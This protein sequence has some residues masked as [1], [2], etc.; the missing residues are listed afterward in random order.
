MITLI[1]YCL[2]MF[3]LL[4]IGESIPKKIA[5][6]IFTFLE[7]GFFTLLI[8]QNLKSKRN[9]FVVI[10]FSVAFVVFQVLYLTLMKHRRQL[11]SIPIG[12]E[13]IFIFIFIFLFLSEQIKVDTEPIYSNY[14]FWIAIGLVVYLAG[15]LFIYLQANYKYW[16]FTWLVEIIKNV[17]IAV[18]VYMYSNKPHQRSKQ[19]LPNLDFIV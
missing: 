15:S 5:F 6:I 17:L 14:F 19:V 16:P 4:Q 11:D 2:C 7:Y 13:T 18:A 8:F 10:L 9:R 1:S 3:T 12:V